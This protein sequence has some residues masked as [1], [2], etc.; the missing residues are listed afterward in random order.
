MASET[1]E[2]Q[3]HLIDSGDLQAIL[4]TIVEHEATYEILRFEVGRTNESPSRLTIR[5][6]TDTPTSLESLLEK[7]SPYGCYVGGAPDV[8]L[9]VADMNGAAPEDFY[10]TTNHRTEVRLDGAWMKVDAQRMDAAIVVA[11]GKAFCRKLRDVRKGD[12]IV[13][14]MHGVRVMPDVQSRDRP[15]FG[16]M[17]NEVSSERRVETAVARVAET[18]RAART[19]GGKIGFLAR[20]P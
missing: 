1:V 4:T 3:G 13:C 16:F 9:R 5:L 14:G 20:P 2:A 15:S 17:T 10:S 12:R 11:G 7:L 6:N 8:L 18:I 19:R